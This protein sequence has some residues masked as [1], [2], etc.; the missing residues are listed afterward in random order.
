MAYFFSLLDI[1]FWHIAVHKYIYTMDSLF[2]RCH[3]SY[4]FLLTAQSV[5]LAASYCCVTGQYKQ[6]MD[7]VGTETN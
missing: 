6:K 3:P 5:D 4:S 7:R 1:A 2:Y